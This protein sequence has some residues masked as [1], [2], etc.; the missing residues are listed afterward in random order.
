MQFLTPYKF[1]LPLRAEHQD[2]LEHDFTV[3]AVN[4]KVDEAAGTRSFTLV[5][6]HPGIIW[7][8]LFQT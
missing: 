8:G 7:T 5:V 3:T 4:D 1:D 6:N 2:P